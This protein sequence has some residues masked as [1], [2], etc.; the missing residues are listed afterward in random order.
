MAFGV[1]RVKLELNKQIKSIY[2]QAAKFKLM[3]P[4]ESLGFPK[5][6][7]DWKYFVNESYWQGGLKERRLR[8]GRLGRARS[9]PSPGFICEVSLVYFPLVASRKEYAEARKSRRCGKA[10]RL[11]Q[12]QVQTTPPRSKAGRSETEYRSRCWP[13]LATPFTCLASC[14]I[15]LST[16]LLFLHPRWNLL[17][18]LRDVT[19][20]APYSAV[21]PVASVITTDEVSNEVTS[22]RWLLTRCPTESSV[23]IITRRIDFFSKLC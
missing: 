1:M 16:S 11:A 3:I 5:P 23:A 15:H 12:A 17:M 8:A 4:P 13:R 14:P 2:S 18:N 9:G 6:F 21:S 10:G 22:E 20:I 19:L 7:S